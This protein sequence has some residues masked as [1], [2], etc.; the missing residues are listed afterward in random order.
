MTRG[1]IDKEVQQLKQEVSRISASSEYNGR[2]LLTGEGEG[3]DIQI[4]TH[5]KAEEDRFSFDPQ[6]INVSLD[7]L[8]LGDFNVKE[9]D[10]ARQGLEV[11]DSSV[12]TLVENRAELGALQNR[13]QS[14]MNN[15]RIYDENLTGANSR[16]RDAD[17]AT[18]SAELAKNNILASAGASVLSQAN[19]NQ[20]IALKLLG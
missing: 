7:H 16:I 14:S 4:G 20:M 19:S 9:K 12:K 10:S 11:I 1:F 2:K 5:N 8:G 18:E 13:L 17:M 3:I 6:K 15:L